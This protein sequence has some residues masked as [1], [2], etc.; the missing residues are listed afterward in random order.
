MAKGFKISKMKDE[1]Q[2]GLE[3]PLGKSP[4][5]MTYKYEIEFD[6]GPH[7]AASWVV[8]LDRQ[9]FEDLGDSIYNE[10]HGHFP[11]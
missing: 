10:I 7:G 1:M 4:P 9:T 8:T 5:F 6:N 3:L 2:E 11:G